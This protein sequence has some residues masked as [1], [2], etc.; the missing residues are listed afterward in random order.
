MGL[1]IVLLLV[2]AC[3]DGTDD[4]DGDARRL[5]L[6]PIYRSDLRLFAGFSFLDEPMPGQHAVQAA[7][8]FALAYGSDYP[9]TLRLAFEVPEVIGCPPSSPGEV[10]VDRVEVAQSS[11]FTAT[12]DGN[13]VIAETRLIGN[14][15][16]TV[17]G[18]IWGE[19]GTPFGCAQSFGQSHFD[20]VHTMQV[21]VRTPASV[22]FSGCLREPWLVEA[23]A[24]L[25]SPIV[26]ATDLAGNEMR[27]LNVD[28]RRPVPLTLVGQPGAALRLADPNGGLESVIFD[29]PP[30]LVDL[31][32]SLGDRVQ[33]EVIETGAINNW[34]VRFLMPG[35]N[36]DSLDITSGGTIPPNVG[37]NIGNRILPVIEELLRDE[38][39]LCSTP[40]P[41]LRIEVDGPACALDP[42]DAIDLSDERLRILTGGWLVGRT[43]RVV[44]AG[45]CEIS[46]QGTE[47]DGGAGLTAR[48]TLDIE[49]ADRF[50]DLAGD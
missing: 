19:N 40:R 26:L 33:I 49:D 50:V 2:A 24:S 41:D 39:A 47:Y 9:G 5:E 38:D 17:S 10:Y 14:Y 42:P 20:Y 43:I 23:K 34:K 27:P 1:V 6:A 31:R 28:L 46:M 22:R 44:N 29:T 8:Q 37:S 45:R 48:V 13:D 12:L 15:E 4:L 21:R 16:F 36:T 18:Q 7:S 11:G 25:R 32:S 3:S 30:G 35:V